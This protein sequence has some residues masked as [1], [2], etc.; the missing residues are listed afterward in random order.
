MRDDELRR[1]LVT[2]NPWWAAAASGSDASAWAGEHRIL[3]DRARHD[4][5]YRTSVLDDI[6]ATEPDAPLNV[7]VAPLR[8]PCSTSPRASAPRPPSTPAK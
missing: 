7:S 8:S 5:G 3:R 2:A 6:A 4:L 1:T